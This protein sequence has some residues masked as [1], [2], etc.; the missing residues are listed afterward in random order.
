LS[1]A[2]PGVGTATVLVGTGGGDG[3]I[4]GLPVI[5]GEGPSA[6]SDRSAEDI[7]QEVNNINAITKSR[8]LIFAFNKD[9]F[10]FVDSRLKNIPLSS[11]AL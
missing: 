3:V 7:A 5:E 1:S 4:V 10:G 2:A 11:N 8:V 6:V 9:L